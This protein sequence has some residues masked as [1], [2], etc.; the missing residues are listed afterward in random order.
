MTTLFTDRLTL[1]PL[2]QAA[3]TA[4]MYALL[5]DP[6]L[7]AYLDESMPESEAWLARRYQV[8]ERG[9][10]ADGS[11]LWFNWVLRHRGSGAAV[12]YV[13]ATV[14]GTQAD[15]A[16]VVGADHWRLGY[17]GEA[18][19]AMLTHLF[20]DRGVATAEAQVDARN[21]AS[22]RLVE[23]LGF[24]RAERVDGDWV[25]RLPARAPAMQLAEWRE[26][27]APLALALWGDPAVM[28]FLPDDQLPDPAAAERC[29]QGAMAAQRDHGVAL[30]KVLEGGRF[31]GAC[32]VHPDGE[33]GYHFLAEA[34][35]RG[36]ATRAGLLALRRAGK[37]DVQAW[38]H[39]DNAASARVLA[40]LGG[41]DHGL[42][43][44]EHRWSV[45][46]LLPTSPDEIA[47]LYDACAAWFQATGAANDLLDLFGGRPPGLCTK[48]VL[49]VW[50]GGRLCGV[51]DMV[52]GYPDPTGWFIG[53]VLLHPEVRG[54]GLG[55]RVVAQLETMARSGGG[56]HIGIGVLFTNPDGRRFWERVGYRVTRDAPLLD[57]GDA[58]PTA[59]V[60]HK[61]L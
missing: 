48:E 32:G 12:G 5:S 17:G 14:T 28:R 21:V 57:A 52:R 25:Y 51:V 46:A 34:Q 56:T 24:E 23:R 2:A 11:Q 60:M 18:S 19:L 54:H 45:P 33:L 35:G 44:G 38:T 13:Q 9:H 47:P 6:R 49:A 58:T 3:H 10:S 37:T 42:D 43:D 31:V 41:R 50:E 59:W 27:D 53:L 16:W 39:P 29:V 36:L 4:E 26:G 40:K 30:W 7:Y 22:M 8:L 15:V 61:E 20:A 55:A 1:E